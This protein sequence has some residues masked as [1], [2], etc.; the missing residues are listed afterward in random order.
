MWATPLQLA[1]ATAILANRGAVV[2]PRI[3]KAVD[4]VPFEPLNNNPKPEVFADDADY[5]RYIHEAMTMVVTG[6]FLM[7]SGTTA[8][9]MSQLR[10]RIAPC[11][12]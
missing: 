9:P 6:R 3:L 10:C 7:S 5:W 4:G 12:T 2:Q 11:L 1:T 8:Q